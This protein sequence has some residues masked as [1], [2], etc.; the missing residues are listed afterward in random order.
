MYLCWIICSHYS[1]PYLPWNPAELTLATLR[2]THSTWN[3]TFIVPDQRTRYNFC[4]PDWRWRTS[5]RGHLRP[6]WG[7]VVGQNK[8][9]RISFYWIISLLVGFDLRIKFLHS[10]DCYLHPGLQHLIWCPIWN[11][12]IDAN[13]GFSSKEKSR[14]C[15]LLCICVCNTIK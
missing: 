2:G 3:M 10:L 11:N 9:L 6:W 12:K 15:S 1:V 7:L 14:H 8:G 13:F 5:G 4:C